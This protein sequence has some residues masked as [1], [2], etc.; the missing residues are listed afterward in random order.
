MVNFISTIQ[1]YKA[2]EQFRDKMD[3]C[4]SYLKSHKKDFLSNRNC[5]TMKKV[6]L[7][8]VLLMPGLYRFMLKYK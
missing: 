4:L 5:S 2:K 3:H 6:K 8:F 1:K 7:A